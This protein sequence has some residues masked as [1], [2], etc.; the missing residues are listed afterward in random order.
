MVVVD[1][2]EKAPRHVGAGGLCRVRAMPLFL[3]TMFAA[4]VLNWWS[5]DPFTEKSQWEISDI[6]LK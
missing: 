2:E 1:V 5:A 3:K 4:V 6:I